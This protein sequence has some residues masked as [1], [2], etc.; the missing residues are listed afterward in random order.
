MILWDVA[1]CERIGEPL[2]DHK[3]EV[4]SVAFAPDG[5]ILASAS[6]DGTVILWDVATRKPHGELRHKNAFLSNAFLLG[7]TFSPDGKTLA[8]AAFTDDVILWD[9]A[10]RAR[11]W[12]SHFTTAP[13]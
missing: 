5:K 8:S 4:Y 12:A 7:V 6:A 3:G 10:T 2:A 13:A 11:R 1:S 9:V